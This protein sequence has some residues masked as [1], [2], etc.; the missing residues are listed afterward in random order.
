LA[1]QY[2]HLSVLFVKRPRNAVGPTR[3]STQDRPKSGDL[4]AA[5]TIRKGETAFVN[6]GW[7]KQN[8]PIFEV[9]PE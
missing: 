1:L 7:Q 4:V 3:P 6:P 9:E 5:Q 2:H 8:E